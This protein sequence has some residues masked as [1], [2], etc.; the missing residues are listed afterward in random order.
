MFPFITHTVNPLG[1]GPCPYQCSYCWA[2]SMKNRYKYEKYKGPWRIYEKE[3][4]SYNYGDFPFPFDMVDIGHPSIPE[5]IIIELL[6]WMIKQ[7][8]SML[9]L[10]KN[11]IFYKKYHDFLPHNAVLGATIECDNPA[12]LLKHSKAPNPW[13]RLDA[14]KW[15]SVN[16]P[17]NK[18]FIS[19][20]PIMTFTN[21]FI[22]RIRDIGPWGVAV[23]YDNYHNHL[24]EPRI[25]DTEDLISEL[26]DFTT[27]YIKT[28]R[29]SLQKGSK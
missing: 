13:R 5:E 1:G 18:L 23:G 14:M 8:C 21:R 6:V 11:P 15:L 25:E 7:P 4:K 29:T 28:L 10:S 16:Q 19:I 3:L 26:Q 24:P 22:E 12:L 20:E 27:V 9:M 2:T 17:Q